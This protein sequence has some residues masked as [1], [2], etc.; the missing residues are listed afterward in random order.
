MS[1]LGVSLPLCAHVCFKHRYPEHSLPFKLIGRVWHNFASVPLCLLSINF[2]AY[3]TH[4]PQC[5][6][7]K[8]DQCRVAGYRNVGNCLF[9]Q[10]DDVVRHIVRREACLDILLSFCCDP[11]DELRLV[12]IPI[13]SEQLWNQLGITE[14][15]VEFVVKLLQS[16]TLPAA[17]DAPDAAVTLSSAETEQDESRDRTSFSCLLLDNYCNK[18]VLF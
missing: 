9:F 11:D 3:L 1:Q 8:F 7:M 6:A 5:G 4:I 10:L 16:L 12:A 15:L 17:Q 14:Y 18:A 13:V 2:V